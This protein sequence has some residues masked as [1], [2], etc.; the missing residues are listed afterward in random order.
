VALYRILTHHLR[1][2]WSNKIFYGWYIVAVGFLSHVACA[3]HM[4]STLSMFL[5]PLT[6]DLGVSR[7][8]FSLLRSG[9]ILIGAALALLLGPMVDRFGA[10]GT[11]R[12]AR[13]RRK[14]VSIVS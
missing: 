14:M 13:S 11:W 7:G 3:F 1:R 5:K 9:E 2:R 12:S 8:I 4:S 6:E 10:A